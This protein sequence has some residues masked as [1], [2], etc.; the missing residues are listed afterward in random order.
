M[1]SRPSLEAL[2]DSIYAA[3]LQRDPPSSRFAAPLE[4]QFA[5]SALRNSRTIVRFAST[6][7]VLLIVV[8]GAERLIAGMPLPLPVNGML[9]GVIGSS[10][11]LLWLAWSGVYERLYLPFARVLVPLRNVLI[12]TQSVH[13][14]ALGELDALIVLPLLIIGPLYFSGLSFRAGLFAAALAC[15]A[16]LLAAHLF[17]LPPQVA[18]RTAAFLLTTLPTCAVAAWLIERHARRGF[19]EGQLIGELAQQDVLTWTKNRRMFD[20]SLVRLWRQATS[21]ARALSILLMDI[22]YFKAYNDRYGHQA[23]DAAL[24]QAAQA[25][26]RCARRPLD[27]VA[28]YGGEEFGV[29]LYDTDRAGA[30]AA[31]EAMRQAVQE[32]S[33]EHDGSR[34][35]DVLTISVGVA[36][37]EPTAWRNPYGALQLADEALYQAKSK[38][39]NRVELM[40]D[41]AHRLLVTG[42]FSKD[43]IGHLKSDTSA[44]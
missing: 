17:H 12:A 10:L 25:I 36:V 38:G 28:R 30:H 43:I 4:A 35:S 5:R 29:I 9:A 37:L 3:E 33:I 6:L 20:E 8:R 44:G 14:A 34:C 1:T 21:D 22:D 31:A 42:E 7:T 2:P 19:L 24:R 11:A 23:G 40:D 13:A 16:E 41:V 18:L 26:Q 39:R 27:L 32:L 15:A